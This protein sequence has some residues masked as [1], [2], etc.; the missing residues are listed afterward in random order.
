M[1]E[2]ARSEAGVPRGAFLTLLALDDGPRHG[3]EISTW[4]KQ[5][6][7]GFFT[8]S[9]GALYPILH[10]LERDGLVAGAWEAVGPAKARR[11]YKLLAKGRKALA[12]ERAAWQD[13][14]AALARLLGAKA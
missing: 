9:F 5:R 3:Y 7:A 12:R 10:K 13:S 2:S 14:T 4:V 11:I 6:S 1:S 8:L